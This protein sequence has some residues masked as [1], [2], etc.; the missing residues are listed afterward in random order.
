MLD[1][2]EIK[3]IFGNS[4][5]FYRIKNLGMGTKYEMVLEA[6]WNVQKECPKCFATGIDIF[7]NFS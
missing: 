5:F 1:R 2:C 6:L 3:K 4:H 7:F